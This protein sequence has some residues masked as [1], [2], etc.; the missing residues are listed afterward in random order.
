VVILEWV[1]FL[2]GEAQTLT[3]LMEVQ[4]QGAEYLFSAQQSVHPFFLEGD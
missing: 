3:F 2:K 4:V 1:L